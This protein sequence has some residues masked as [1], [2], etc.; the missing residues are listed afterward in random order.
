MRYE[1]TQPLNMP[2]MPS[3]GVSRVD[4]YRY[5]DMAFCFGT[6]SFGDTIQY[7][8]R[9][10]RGVRVGKDTEYIL[11]LPLYNEVSHLE[12]GVPEGSSFSFVPPV[13]ECPIVLYGT[14]IAQGACASRPAMAWANIVGRKLELSLINLGF[15]GNGKLEY[16]I[17]ELICEQYP[18]IVISDCMPNMVVLIAT[19]LSGE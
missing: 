4:L 13:K 11:Y 6:Y 19:R 18:S 2:H 15:S 16:E 7:K 10:D 3:T 5:E 1:I 17:I 9:V 8:Y 14:S 12:I